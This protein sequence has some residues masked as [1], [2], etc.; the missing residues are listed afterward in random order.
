MRLDGRVRRAICYQ[1][2]EAL[3]TLVSGLSFLGVPEVPQEKRE[4]IKNLHKLADEAKKANTRFA[5][6]FSD[7]LEMIRKNPSGW[8]LKTGNVKVPMTKEL[9]ATLKPLFEAQI[10]YAGPLGWGVGTGGSVSFCLTNYYTDATV[11]IWYAA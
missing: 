10:G 9:A 4:K 7:F 1:L 11:C 5:R 6:A 3:N 8:V 2:R